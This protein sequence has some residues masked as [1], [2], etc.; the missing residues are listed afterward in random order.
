MAST[1]T[2]TPTIPRNGFSLLEMLVVVALIALVTLFALPSITSYFRVSLGTASRELAGTIKEAYNSAVITG[3]VH[4][5][6]YDLT[7]HQYWVESGPP[8]LLLDSEASAER[9][10]RRK[11]FALEKDEPPPSP[12]KLERA[13]TRKKAELPTGVT[14]EDV[15][16]QKTKEPI[17]AGLAYTH[18]FPH[19]LTE[20]TLIHI[21]DTS[22]HH[23]T[24]VISPL[25]GKTDLYERYATDAELNPK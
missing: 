3:R 23:N 18:V 10:R 1:K 13:V 4:R 2:S 17:T 16:T 6:V 24:L 12:F 25:V 14:F 20:R 21:Q 11:R 5:I 19:G 9:E 7:K 15:V 22:K 8:T